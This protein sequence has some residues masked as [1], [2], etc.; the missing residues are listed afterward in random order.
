MRARATVG[1][2]GGYTFL[3]R[4]PEPLRAR[5][6]ARARAED[7]PIARVVRGALQEYLGP[8]A[9]VGTREGGS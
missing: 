6:V 9:A 8:T 3:L 4:L 2:R 1:R 5:L 7:R